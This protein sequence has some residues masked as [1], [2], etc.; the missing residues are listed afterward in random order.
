MSIAASPRPDKSGDG[1]FVTAVTIL[2]NSSTEAPEFAG[3]ELNAGG[4]SPAFN[5][6]RR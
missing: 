3:P 1:A 2:D 4:S 5:M 6:N